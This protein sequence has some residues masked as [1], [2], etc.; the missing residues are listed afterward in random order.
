MSGEGLAR[1]VSWTLVRQL[2]S[3]LLGLALTVLLTRMLGAEH[4]GWYS[5]AILLPTLLGT[6]L[7]LGM[8]PATVYLIGAQKA[9]PGDALQSNLISA[10]VLSSVGLGL[11]VLII[12]FFGESLFPGVPKG[13]LHLAL[14][15]L[16]AA[17]L[18]AL[19]HAVVH[20][21]GAFAWLNRISLIPGLVTLLCAAYFVAHLKLGIVGALLAF[22]AG[23]TV[24][25]LLPL[26][27]L[28]RESDGSGG[29][30][31][32]QFRRAAISYGLRAHPST[33]LNILN[34]RLDMILLSV[35]TGS[36]AVG[37]YAVAV[38]IAERLWL[39]PQAV[40]TVLLP[41][42]A[43]MADREN[44]RR[45]LTCSAARLTALV[46]LLSSGLLALIAPLV[47]APIFGAEFAPAATGLLY[48]LPGI[49]LSAWG[50]VFGNDLAARG[51]PGINAWI[52]AVNLLVNVVANL[53]LIPKFGLN[54]A[55][56]ATSLSYS[57]FALAS[58]L[59]YL[60]VTEQ[61]IGVLLRWNAYDRAMIARVRRR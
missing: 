17:M 53:I 20:G 35:L 15:I 22:F 32:R 21:M 51:R 38:M 52:A 18:M 4:F 36:T 43:G 45:A 27:R 5:L 23:R 57:V 39:L 7:D 31:V 59:A 34:Y 47:I 19:I 54:G 46:V 29:D 25:A 48:L 55:A 11:G 33:I 61:P 49:V 42:I 37:I 56:I 44:D 30:G 3:A 14:V 6:A 2:A 40:S 41:T 16:P 8:T 58:A 50:R 28:M 1:S 24:A 26:G 13:H 12:E 60:R 10:V 9:L